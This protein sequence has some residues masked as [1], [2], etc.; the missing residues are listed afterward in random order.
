MELNPVLTAVI[1]NDPAQPNTTNDEVWEE[2]IIR[3]G[4]DGTGP[5][6][7]DDDE[8]DVEEPPPGGE[9]GNPNPPKNEQRMYLALFLL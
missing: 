1:S 7:T 8:D 4:D 5:A 2:E 6:P 3:D 9:D